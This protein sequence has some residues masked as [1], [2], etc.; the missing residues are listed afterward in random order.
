MRNKQN[1]HRYIL[2]VCI[3]TFNTYSISMIQIFLVII[4]FTLTFIIQHFNGS[5]ERPIYVRIKNLLRR[6]IYDAVELYRPRDISKQTS[7]W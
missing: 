2:N 6:D 7:R 4:N 1:T 5:D 3:D